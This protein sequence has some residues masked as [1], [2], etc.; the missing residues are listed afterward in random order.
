[1]SKTA[2]ITKNQTAAVSRG[3]RLKSLRMMSGLSRKNLADKYNLS[4]STLQSW[5]DAKAGGLTD[6][7]AKKIILALQA[8]GV[9][10][11]LDWLLYGVGKPPQLAA[12]YSQEIREE[13]AVYEASEEHALV[14]ELLIFRQYNPNAVDYMVADNGM[15]PFYQKGDY[16]AGRRRVGKDI[17]VLIGKNCIVETKANEI[18]LRRLRQGSKEN[19]YTLVCINLDTSVT[20]LV[21]YDCE[22]KS[23]AGVIWHRKKAE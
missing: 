2:T 1:M 16:V 5:E 4:A 20:D 3:K 18:Y 11:T 13:S 23:A 19:L 10:C 14:K 12:R 8:E 21:L 9:Q 6:K 17:K 15:E 7:G 22:L